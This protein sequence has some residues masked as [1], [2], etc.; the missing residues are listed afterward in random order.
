MGENHADEDVQALAAKLDSLPASTMVVICGR[1]AFHAENAMRNTSARQRDVIWRQL[2]GQVIAASF[3]G[4]KAGLAIAISEHARLRYI[5]RPAVQ[6]LLAYAV[7]GQLLLSAKADNGSLNLDWALSEAMLRTGFTSF[8]DN[9][10]AAL[11][12][13]RSPALSSLSMLMLIREERHADRGLLASS[14]VSSLPLVATLSATRQSRWRWPPPAS[15]LT[16]TESFSHTVACSGT[17]IGS[18]VS[19]SRSIS[20]HGQCGVL[21]NR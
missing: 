13:L 18:A 12:T 11:R 15:S 7:S 9:S 8:A 17:W 2:Q 3:G 16:S 5:P 21:H 10:L 20:T 4:S 1:P 6:S 19:S 14:T